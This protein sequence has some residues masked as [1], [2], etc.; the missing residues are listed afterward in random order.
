MTVIL[1][2]LKSHSK[3]SCSGK[4]AIIFIPL[5]TCCRYTDKSDEKRSEKRQIDLDITSKWRG[6][7]LLLGILPHNL[8]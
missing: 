2:S 1:W 7:V 6:D 3:Q 8:S 5:L 4:V